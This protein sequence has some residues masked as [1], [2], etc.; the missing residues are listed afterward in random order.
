[1]LYNA[2]AEKEARFFIRTELSVCITGRD[3]IVDGMIPAGNAV[4]PVVVLLTNNRIVLASDQPKKH[5]ELS[6]ACCTRG[7]SLAGCA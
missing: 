2:K 6:L 5:P 7:S 3:A 4:P 1:M